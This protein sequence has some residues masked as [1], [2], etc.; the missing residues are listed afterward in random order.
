[1]KEESTKSLRPT[2]VPVDTPPPLAPT[3]IL[4]ALAQVKPHA[5]LKDVDVTMHVQCSVP[6]KLQMHVTMNK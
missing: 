1:M 3:S 2:T 5:S 6:V 4:D